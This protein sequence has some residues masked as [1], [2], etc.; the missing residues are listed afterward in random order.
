MKYLEAKPSRD[1]PSRLEFYVDGQK[2]ANMRCLPG[3]R[4]TKLQIEATARVVI[5]KNRKKEGTVEADRRDEKD[6]HTP[7]TGEQGAAAERADQGDLP[8]A[9]RGGKKKAEKKSSDT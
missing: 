8:A 3:V 6:V 1:D 4:N 2:V 7:D 9:K 5:D